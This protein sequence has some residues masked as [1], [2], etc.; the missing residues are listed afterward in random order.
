MRHAFE[1]SLTSHLDQ[2]LPWIVMV[3]WQEKRHVSNALEAWTQTEPLGLEGVSSAL[4]CCATRQILTICEH[5]ASTCNEIRNPLH[6]LLVLPALI[7]GRA[8]EA[9]NDAQET[10]GS[11]SRRRRHY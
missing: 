7:S 3:L 8:P 11:P 2:G 4:N 9:P 1:E 10:F 5:G 6:S